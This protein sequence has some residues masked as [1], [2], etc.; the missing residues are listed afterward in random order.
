M[1]PVTPPID[2]RPDC[3]PWLNAAVLT[4]LAKKADERFITVYRFVQSLREGSSTGEIMSV[5]KARRRATV[6]RLPSAGYRRRN[7]MP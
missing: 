5:A 7:K 6:A 2:R 3:P 4:A 1:N